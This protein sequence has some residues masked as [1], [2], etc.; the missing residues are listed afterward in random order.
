MNLEELAIIVCGSLTS[1]TREDKYDARSKGVFQVKKKILCL[2]GGGIKGVFVATILKVLE[3]GLP[4]ADVGIGNYFDMIVGTSTGGIIAAGLSLHI[5]AEKICNLYIENATRI[6]PQDKKCF[7]FLKRIAGAKYQSDV[8]KNILE[9]TFGSKTIGEC[10]TRLLIPSYNLTTNSVQIFKTPHATDLQIDYKRKIVDVLLAT[11][12]A[13]TYFPPH[14]NTSGVYVDGGIG[15]NNPSFIALVEALSDRCG[16]AIDDIYLLSIGCTE[17]LSSFAR[18]TE[19]MGASDVVKLISAFMNAESQY[20]DN[21]A[22]I[23][24]GQG[25][26]MRINYLDYAGRAGLDRVNKDALDFLQQMG[27]NAAQRYIADI[28]EMFLDQETEKYTPFY[29]GVN[30]TNKGAEL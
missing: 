26:Y 15:A 28:Q 30:S 10:Q 3:E 21:I 1:V 4:R 12:A 13:P 17:S 27:Q 8:L 24:L 20:S 9:E 29:T 14:N 16:W 25:H 6:F 19:T 5:P 11:T 22:K 2:D 18:G 7:R 23:L